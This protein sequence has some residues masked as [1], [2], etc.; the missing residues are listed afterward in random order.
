MPYRSTRYRNQKKTFTLSVKED[1]HAKVARI[2]KNVGCTQQEVTDYVMTA[3]LSVIEDTMTER[4][5]EL[6]EKEQQLRKVFMRER[7]FELKTRLSE[8]LVIPIE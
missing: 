5:L 1:I 3:A 4:L 8:M 2:A 6:R 7:A